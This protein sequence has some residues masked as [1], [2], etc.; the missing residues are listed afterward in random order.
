M[1][2]LPRV[3]LDNFWKKVEN[4]LDALLGGHRI[5]DARRVFGTDRDVPEDVEGNQWIGDYP[6]E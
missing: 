5:D 4:E 1:K 2:Q 6:E 3:A